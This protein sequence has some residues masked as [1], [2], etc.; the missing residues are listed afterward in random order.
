MSPISIQSAVDVLVSC[1]L[2][3]STSTPQLLLMCKQYQNIMHQTFVNPQN[4]E[5]FPSWTLFS[6]TTLCIQ[7]FQLYTQEISQ[8]KGWFMINQSYSSDEEIKSV[9]TCSKW[10]DSKVEC[11]QSEC[12]FRDSL[13]WK[14]FMVLLLVVHMTSD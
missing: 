9:N 11:L 7:G 12:A 10:L 14:V 6:T 4:N 1:D 5:P 8:S 2:S 13:Q 3:S